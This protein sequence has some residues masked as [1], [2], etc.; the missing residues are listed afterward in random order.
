MFSFFRRASTV[1]RRRE[2]VLRVEKLENRELCASLAH[3][4]RPANSTPRHQPAIQHNNHQLQLQRQ[5]AKMHVLTMAHM[6]PGSYNVSHHIN[7]AAVDRV[8]AHRR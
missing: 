1:Q 6:S 5:A 2:T 7:P 3:S 4:R 8:M